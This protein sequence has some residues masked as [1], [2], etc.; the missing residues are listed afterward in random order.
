MTEFDKVIII[1]ADDRVQFILTSHLSSG[2]VSA[3]PR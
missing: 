2:E 3:R 1:K